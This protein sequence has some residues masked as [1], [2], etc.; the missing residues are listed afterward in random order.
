MT[1]SEIYKQL[2]CNPDDADPANLL[3]DIDRMLAGEIHF[4]DLYGKYV[5]DQE[6]KTNDRNVPPLSEDKR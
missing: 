3:I 6:R 1:R 2:I 5:K 4:G